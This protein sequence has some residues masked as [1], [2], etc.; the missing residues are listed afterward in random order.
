MLGG[1][2]FVGTVSAYA[3]YSR[4]LPDPAE[5]FSKLSFDEPSLIY[6][7]SGQV[8]LASFGERN[9]ELVK[10]DEIPGELIDATTAIE[11]K[12]FW[13]N[14]GFD[15]G[16]F[17]AASIDT[18]TGHPRGGSTI[19]QQLVRDRLLP[20]E[21]FSG[22]VYDRKIREIIQ[23]IRLTQ[24]YPGETG[25]QDI[26]TAYLNGNFYGNQSY[27]V[28]AAAKGYFDKELKDLT[29]AQAA[30]LAAIPKSPTQF[31][32]VRNAER[33]CTVTV[34]EGSD[35]PANKLKLAVPDTAPIVAR[36]NNVLEL[37]KTRSVLS[38]SKHSIQE[39]EDAKD[40]DVVLAPQGIPNWLAPHFV[41]Q[42][43]D[44]LA[45]IICGADAADKCELLD[46]GG[47]H[48]KTTLNWKMQQTV[49]KWLYIAGR[50]THFKNP[51]P[52]WER[53]KVP[54]ADY[55]WLQ[56]LGQ[57]RIF[58]DAG[59]VLD[60]RTG[61]LL[62]MG[63]SAGYYLDGDERMQPQ[64]DV[65]SAGFRQPGSAIKP[66]NY[67]TGLDQHSLTASTMFMHV[68]TDFGNNGASWT[69][70]EDDDL[71]RGPVRLRS[72]LQF[73]FNIAS[74]K[75]GLIIGLPSAFQHFQDFGLEFLPGTGP[76]ISQSIGTLETHPAQML[77]AYGA[78][79]NGGVLMPRTHI[80][81]VTDKDGK[82]IYP[83]AGDAPK[84]KR[85]NTEQASYIIT[86]ILNGNTIK[87][88][89]PPW[90]RWQIL[91]DGKRRPAAYKTGT[92]DDNKDV[93]AYGYLAPPADAKAPALAVGV[94]MGNSDATPNNGTLSLASS[95]PLWSK[96]L[97][98]VSNGLPI[99][100]FKRPEGLVEAKVDAFSGLLPGPY[101]VSTVNELFIK[102][103]APTRRD[104]LHVILD[105][106]QATGLLWQDG[107]TG[108]MVQG[109]FLD[110]SQAEPGFPQ[111][112]PYTQEWAARAARGTG[113]VGGPRNTRTTYF[114]NFSFNPFGR[115]WGGKF[116]PT[117]VCQPVG[118][119]CRG[120]GPPI[121]PSLC[122]SITPSP[123]K[124][125]G[126]KPQPTTSPLP[127]ILPAP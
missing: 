98:E 92:T 82:V 17:I 68:V 58:N 28:K 70:G 54:K 55:A 50:T 94:W 19:T 69:P 76:V 7:R 24:A 40:E 46:T 86:D 97:T 107:C 51:T 112:Q 29:L 117:E 52:I 88:V 111:W 9:R 96:I 126:G 31:D 103:T 95:A 61:Q 16:G 100:N 90:A 72:A 27:G 6:D 42:V 1:V 125:G 34:E 43:R 80:L 59:G 41:W 4:D 114:Y 26:I 121:L 12:D 65:F 45:Q 110:F 120:N 83:T 85:V 33:L 56:N 57:K 13:K 35:C 123:T 11:D 62:A 71:E 32:L 63:G 105:I 44:Q 119:I 3:Y 5:M 127:S 106:D 14:P 36:R 87:A 74:I 102:G 67:I 79:A 101:T 89:N 64:Y 81:E 47:Y 8:Q 18:L 77:S 20:A 99:A 49:E 38:G 73:S 15:L 118:D 66:L 93:A 122:P 39:Y 84:G 2:G 104:D 115:T 124:G 25:K 116:A 75:A 108:P 30:L 78:I 91:E 53:L 10:F 21:A 113:V 22:S 109:A 37:M 60:Y 23:S 48:V